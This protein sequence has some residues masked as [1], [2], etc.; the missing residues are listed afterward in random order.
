M[1]KSIVSI[2]TRTP[3]HVGAGSS[4]GVV[5]LPIIRERHTGYPVI[6]GAS[7]KGVLADLWNDEENREWKEVKDR[8]VAFRRADSDA[9]K[10]FGVDSNPKKAATGNLLVGEGRI[11]VFPVRSA[12]AGFAWVTCP[13][14]LGRYLR[15]IGKDVDLTGKLEGMECFATKSLQFT[16][17][18]SAASIILEE[19]ALNCKNDEKNILAT[20]AEILK[21]MSDDSLWKEEL[22]AHLV[23]LSAEMFK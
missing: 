3:M 19:Y 11:V 23:I 10:L 17:K 1:K 16:P 5:D 9:E 14:A 13:L 15:D 4:V 21:G 6:P 12:K 8:R 7:L 20:V 22:A 2:Y 18:D